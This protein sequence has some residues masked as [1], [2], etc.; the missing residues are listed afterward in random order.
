MA[1]TPS[2][3]VWS[4]DELVEIFG[5]AD[6]V[7]ARDGLAGGTAVPPILTGKTE[8]TR[9]PPWSEQVARLHPDDRA[10]TVRVWWD[11]LQHP[12][13][14]RRLDVRSRGNTGWRRIDLRYVN[15]LHQAGIRAVLVG[16]ADRGPTAVEEHK[17]NEPRYDRPAWAFQEIDPVGTIL[18]TEGD[19]L[20][21]FGQEPAALAGRNILELLHPDDHDVALAMWVD[22]MASPGATRVIRQRILRPDGS[23]LWIESTVTNRLDEEVGA[24]VG[25][26]LD[27]T[28]RL[29]Q[30]RAVRASQ[31]EFRTLAE[32]VP[33]AV[34]RAAADGRVTFGNGRWF[35]LTSFVGVVEFL[36]DLVAVEHR[37]EWRR[38]WGE[39]TSADG[40]ET[41]TFEYA[42]PD[43]R[44]VLS[45]HCRR[46]H[47]HGGVPSF[48]GVLTDVTD[49]EELR[50]RADHDALTGLLNREAFDRT[51]AASLEAHTDAVVAFVDLD[52]FKEIN[53]ALGHDA[54]DHVLTE[55]ARR[56]TECVRP[57]DAVGRYG[58]DEFVVLC[59]GLPAGGEDGLRKRITHTL[60]P[61]VEWD[62]GEW[63]L[64]ASIG[65]ARARPGDDVTD[66]VRRADHAM[67]EDKH[68]NR[69]RR[70]RNGWWATGPT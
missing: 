39:F 29:E 65:S 22:L 59:S 58:G 40:A 69:R 26:S 41:V 63:P 66:V 17:D 27:I 4:D 5:A 13:E 51:L 46:V 50:H 55:V 70:R 68:V 34:F 62:T 15:L 52:G 37:S 16:I 28:E 18:R 33:T 3:R 53:D 21:V 49:V 23:A 36:V 11:A 8:G 19:A 60:T 64:R 54:G 61:S 42:T 35:H 2:V 31:E 67:Y 47:T 10:A 48:V 20:A 57:G 25:I 12:G 32:E 56:L 1:D 44:S 6:T 9:M 45:L 7:F 38:R 24:M 43:H 30:E 14:L